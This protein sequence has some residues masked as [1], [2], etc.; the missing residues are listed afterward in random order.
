[1]EKK[2]TLDFF[3]LHPSFRTINSVCPSN[4]LDVPFT[5]ATAEDKSHDLAPTLGAE[6]FLS[7]FSDKSLPRVVGNSLFSWVLCKV[8]FSQGHPPVMLSRLKLGWEIRE[9]RLWHCRPCSSR[10]F[11]HQAGPGKAEGRKGIPAVKLQNGTFTLSCK[12]KGFLLQGLGSPTLASRG[13][14]AVSEAEQPLL[15]LGWMRAWELHPHTLSPLHF[16]AKPNLCMSRREQSCCPE[17]GRNGEL[18]V[19]Q[20]VLQ[21]HNSTPSSSPMGAGSVQ[22]SVP[23]PHSCTLRVPCL[24]QLSPGAEPSLPSAAHPWS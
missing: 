20:Q 5:A 3:G 22:H 14:L 15:P 7:S 4:T 6:E 2:I 8:K 9:T 24:P 1:M 16:V 17:Q 11:R 23:C 19:P 10:Q 18:L 21:V 13:C 12:G